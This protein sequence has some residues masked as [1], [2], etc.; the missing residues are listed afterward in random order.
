[1]MARCSK[2]NGCTNMYNMYKP[3]WCE[4]TECPEGEQEPE[5]ELKERQR[6]VDEVLTKLN[7]KL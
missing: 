3:T 6:H 4:D 5:E 7:I 2:C 1:M